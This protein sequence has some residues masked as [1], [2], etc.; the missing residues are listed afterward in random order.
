MAAPSPKPSGGRRKKAGF[1][2]E[3][4]E[5]VG[6]AEVAVS[7]KPTKTV[8]GRVNT[9]HISKAAMDIA[10]GEDDEEEEEPSAKATGG[11]KKKK[12]LFEDEEVDGVIETEVAA[13]AKPTKTVRGRVNRAPSSSA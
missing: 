10:M 12:A 13:S 5:V 11:K 2:N 7:A 4:V 6:E 3:E 1:A 9:P 8:R